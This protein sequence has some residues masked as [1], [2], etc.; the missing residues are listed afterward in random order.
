[1]YL[2]IITKEE[3]FNMLTMDE[4][5]WIEYLEI[6]EET[7]ERRLKDDTPQKIRKKYEEFCL[8]QN[9]HRDEMLPK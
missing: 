3:L 5:P 8:E 4:A 9:N 7:G 1:M 6:D 2:W